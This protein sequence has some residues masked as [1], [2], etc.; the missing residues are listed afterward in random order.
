WFQAM[1]NSADPAH[2]QIL[3]Q[4][5]LSRGKQIN[6]TRGLIDSV[7]HVEYYESAFGL[8]KKRFMKD[9]HWAEHPLVFPN[10]LRQGNATQIRVPMDDEHTQ[11]FFVRFF[12]GQP[13]GYND[14]DP[15]VEYLEP[16]KDPP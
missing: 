2:L 12:E 11:I 6:T 9:G 10:I 1:E 13:A 4:E 8:M 5:S 16:F 7:D 3:H 15:E 14:D